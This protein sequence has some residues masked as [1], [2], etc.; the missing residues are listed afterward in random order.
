M[1]RQ[2]VSTLLPGKGGTS[3]EDPL[4]WKARERTAHYLE[5]TEHILQ[6]KQPVLGDDRLSDRWLMSQL[7]VLSDNGYLG[8][9]AGAYFQETPV[10]RVLG[11]NPAFQRFIED[12][13]QLEEALVAEDIPEVRIAGSSFTARTLNPRR[14]IDSARMTIAIPG[15]FYTLREMLFLID[16]KLQGEL[17]EHPL[18][19]EN[20]ELPS[21]P[22]FWTEVLRGI[23]ILDKNAN[24][25]ID[26]QDRIAAVD[27]DALAHHYGIYVTRD[28]AETLS[29]ASHLSPHLPPA[30][31]PLVTKPIVP[32]GAVFFVATATMKKYE[33]LSRILK[34]QGVDV[35]I[36]PI[37]E[38]VDTYVS[39]KELS[40]SY[41][42]NVEEKIRAGIQSWHAMSEEERVNRLNHLG[43]KKE[44]AF[45]LAE[46]SGF[47][48]DEP[49]IGNEDEFRD[50]AHKIDPNAPFPGVET[51][52]STIGV[53]GLLNF[54]EKVRA[55]FARRPH[56]DYGVTTKSVLALAPFARKEF[57]QTSIYMV[58]ADFKNTFTTAPIPS[59]GPI[60]IDNFII[61]EGYGG[62]TQAQL[63]DHY[64]CSGSARAL[65][66]KGLIKEL[67]LPLLKEQALAEDYA[68]EFTVSVVTDRTDTPP[69]N[70]A[71]SSGMAILPR[72]ST[73]HKP[74]DVQ[75][76][77]LAKSDAVVLALDPAR[78][79]TDFWQ[80]ILLFTSM[81]VGEQTHDKY[82]F[83]KPFKLINPQGAFD[84]L[85]EMVNGFHRVGTVPED[86]HSL[87][88]SAATVEEA[89]EQLKQD[90]LRYRKLHLPGYA[91]QEE[92][93]PLEGRRGTKD[94]NVA[95]FCSAT[96]ENANFKASTHRLAELLV[97]DNFG[98]VSGAG[99]YSMMGEVTKAGHE[100]RKSKKAEH[101]GSNVPHIMEG[102][103]DA[104][105]F[106]TEFLLARNIYERMDYMIERS[107]AF[108]VM[109]GGAGTVQELAVLAWLK[110]RTLEADDPYARSRMAGKEMVLVNLPVEQ[111]RQSQ[112]F[113]DRLISIIPPEDFSRLGIHVVNSVDAAQ[114]KVLELRDKARLPKAA[115]RAESLADIPAAQALSLA[116]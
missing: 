108:V 52:P 82:K 14:V 4:S 69:L 54:F 16:Q 71:D 6:G 28:R 105:G 39:P 10:E 53:N 17:I 12:R 93:N 55:V 72:S 106:M 100:L 65:A 70:V 34:A 47:A 23:K 61:P 107:Q 49:G 59:R 74:I 92:A 68:P 48:F 97:A 46:D 113:Y 84:Y 1:S 62:K 86:P 94:F 91:V 90:R 9:E 75:S 31:E 5:K 102:E 67:R 115:E 19:I 104:S 80:N 73:L 57:D 110:Q 96:N 20:A 76:E 78:A 25:G 99:L 103:G 51:G 60:E 32:E 11:H 24:P 63:G 33:E 109:P 35:R 95:I 15:D 27:Y 85:E 114:Q 29:V 83:R 50:I 88:Q 101:L 87:Y 26:P 21:T 81:I 42:G 79:Q 38:L 56:P 44:Q 66:W 13:H 8:D 111:Q 64:V 112:G 98:L 37:F 22:G 58:G 45:I 36:R 7:R 40:H 43:I 18:I 89:V 116:A 2:D 77:I 3:L 41:E 30:S